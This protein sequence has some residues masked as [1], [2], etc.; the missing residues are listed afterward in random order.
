VVFVQVVFVP[1]VTVPVVLPVDIP[2]VVFAQVVVPVKD[3][4]EVTSPV[5]EELLP[6][7]SAFTPNIMSHTLAKTINPN[8]FFCLIIF[9]YI[10]KSVLL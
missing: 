3:D 7:P 4:P 5:R 6:V 10:I 8:T 9:V 2:P 1:V